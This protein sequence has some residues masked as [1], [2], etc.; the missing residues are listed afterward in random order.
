MRFISVIFLFVVLLVSADGKALSRPFEKPLMS[1]VDSYG[2]TVENMDRSIDFYTN[3]LTFEKRA[4]FVL[5]GKPYDELFGLKGV[6][7]RVVRLRLGLEILNLMEFLNPKGREIPEDAQ[8]N[9]RIFQHIAIVVSDISEAYARLLKNNVTHISVS[10]Q[11]LPVW[12]S[13]AGGI[14]AFYFKDP[15][16]H[17]LEIIQYPPGKGDARWHHPRGRLFLGIDH[18]AIAVESTKRSLE[19]YRSTLGLK[20][21]GESLNYGP[22]QE[23]LS[24][25]PGARVEI[26]SLKAEEGPG[27][28]LLNYL[29]PMTGRAMPGNSKG[30]D[31]W[32]WQIHLHAPDLSKAH[33]VL[34]KIRSAVHGVVPLNNP[35]IAY[36]EAFL[37][38]DPDGHVLLIAH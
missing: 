2:V 26:T 37:A 28:E 32:H 11:K 18:S 4:D 3:I 17:P 30:N 8:S 12:N 36:H 27:I 19:F 25:V 16:G 21:T 6:K 24:N 33:E 22:E 38:A 5:S 35:N 15:D 7:L 31:L 10:P 34:L 14:Q 29:T 20:V 23:K 1:A 9:D 13:N